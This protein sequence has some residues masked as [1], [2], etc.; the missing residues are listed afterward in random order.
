[1]SLSLI[2]VSTQT[3]SLNQFV[4]TLGFT[5]TKKDE[6]YFLKLFLQME[7]DNFPLSSVSEW[8]YC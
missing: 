5:P 2:T 6:A 7:I 4:V 3:Q 1:M 8:Y